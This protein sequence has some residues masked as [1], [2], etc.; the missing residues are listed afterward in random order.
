MELVNSRSDLERYLQKVERYY[1]VG[2]LASQ[3]VDGDYIVQYYEQS[4]LGYKVF[5]SA[6]GSVHMALNFDGEFSKDGYY[7]QARFV[8]SQIVAIGARRV[9]ELASGQGFNSIYIASRNSGLQVVGIDLTPTHVSAAERA[10]RDVKNVTFSIGNFQDLA[11]DNESF[12]LVFEVE[13]ICHATDMRLALEE[14]Y[15]VLRNGGTFVL[16]DGFRQPVK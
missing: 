11:F 1:D 5:H 6:E 9:L 8:E 3:K 14:A 4:E 13:S 16:F 7:E 2:S 12:D 15:R 10:S